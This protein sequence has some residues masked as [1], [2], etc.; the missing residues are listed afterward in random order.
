MPPN[1]SAGDYYSM[2]TSFYLWRRQG[3]DAEWGPKGAQT[4]ESSMLFQ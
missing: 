3:A 1:P 4:I 2:P